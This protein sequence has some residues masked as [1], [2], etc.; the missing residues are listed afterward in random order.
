[1]HQLVMHEGYHD[2]IDFKLCAKTMI[3]VVVFCLWYVAHNCKCCQ[4]S[5]TH[6]VFT[7]MGLR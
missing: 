1:M 4:Y 7:N 6:A 2:D 5:A 3:G